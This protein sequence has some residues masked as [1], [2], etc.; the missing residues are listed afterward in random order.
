MSGRGGSSFFLSWQMRPREA[1]QN[2]EI[3]AANFR[4]RR[5]EERRREMPDERK[6]AAPPLF[7]FNEQPLLSGINLGGHAR[8]TYVRLLTSRRLAHCSSL[9]FISAVEVVEC[10]PAAAAARLYCEICLILFSF[11]KNDD[12]EDRGGER[13]KEEV[14]NKSFALGGDC[15]Y[16]LPPLPSLSLPTNTATGMTNAD[17]FSALEQLQAAPEQVFFF[18]RARR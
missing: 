17:F 1:A 16:V 2:D 4:E 14:I 15:V 9:L 18:T 11:L 5:E 10:D 7:F 8:T 12:D 3:H 6:K 13:E